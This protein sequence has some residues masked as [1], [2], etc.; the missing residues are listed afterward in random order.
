[1]NELQKICDVMKEFYRRGWISTRDGN[2][3]VRI[4]DY[5]YI[6][7]SGAEKHKL[8]VE[9]IVPLHIVNN[10]LSIEGKPSGEVQLHWQL[11][12]VLPMVVLHAH[13]TNIIAAMYA[14]FE[15]DK[16]ALEFPEI[17]RYTKVGKNV[18]SIPPL[19]GELANETFINIAGASVVGL[20]RHG[21]VSIGHTVEEAFQHLE[22]LE[23]ICEIVL[24][25]GVRAYEKF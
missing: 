25:S 23:H 22:R 7:P 8:T 14:G 11:Q 4:K 20:D 3:S 13:P 16:L 5:L 19:T 21:A 10:N 18:P 17:Y 9:D 2:A 6:T 1:M 12:R 24:K 15:L